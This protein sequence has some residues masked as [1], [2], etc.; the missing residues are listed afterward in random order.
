MDLLRAR[1]AVLARHQI[2]HGGARTAGAK[3]GLAQGH[4]CVL[5]PALN[6]CHSKD[7]TDSHRRANV[8]RDENEN[9]SHSHSR[10]AALAGC[11]GDSSSSDRTVVASF[12]PLAFAAQQIGGA[13]IDVRNLT[14]P[15]VEP[16]D[17][18][19]SGSDV[20]HDRRRRPRPLLRRGLP[21]GPRGRD[22]LDVGA[23]RR[24]PRRGRDT[25]RRRGGAR[26]RPPRLARSGPVRRDR[27]ADRRGARSPSGGRAVRD[28]AARPRPRVPRR[29]LRLRARR[30]RHEPRGVRLPGRA[31]R[32]EAGRDHGHLAGG[33]ADAAR[34]RGGRAPG[35]LDRRDDGVLR[36]ARVA[37]A[38]RDGR[39]R[40]RRDDRRARPARRA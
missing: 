20:T 21:A 14:P 9:C 38:C 8:R 30:V 10:V 6:G 13:G 32:A 25:G 11:G 23:R 29:P 1:A 5:A 7:D 19:L 39:P 35:A 15:G 22:R 16:H 33:G 17:L 18:E 37:A 4:L 34:P 40:G 12:Y 2:E 26:R 24:S 36:D 3:A 27:R 28:E 31:L